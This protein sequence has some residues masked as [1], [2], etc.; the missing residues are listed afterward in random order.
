AER[1]GRPTNPVQEAGLFSGAG[2]RPGVCSRVS[3]A[4]SVTR[5]DHE[6]GRMVPGERGEWMP[7]SARASQRQG[8]ARRDAFH[9]PSGTATPAA[10]AYGRSIKAAT[11]FPQRT[12]PA[13][14]IVNKPTATPYALNT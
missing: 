6:P 13:T 3:R 1:V 12:R 5:P 8:Q 11:G 10:S 14:S 2:S 4:T 9:Q 7:A